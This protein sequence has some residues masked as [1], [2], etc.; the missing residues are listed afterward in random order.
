MSAQFS[1][2][3]L[4]DI[5]DGAVSLALLEGILELTLLR[6]EQIIFAAGIQY[7]SSLPKSAT[8]QKCVPESMPCAPWA[9]PYRRQ[10]TPFCPK[11]STVCPQRG[12]A[13]A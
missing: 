7:V 10:C 11:V 6:L 2:C 9:F 4:A 1:I 3:A 13:N 5:K 12:R 8:L